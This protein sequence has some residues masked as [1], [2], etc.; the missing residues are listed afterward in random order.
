MLKFYQNSSSTATRQAKDYLE[1]W[2]L[3]YEVQKMDTDMFTKQ[4]F[5]KILSYLDNVH[6]ILSARSGT[7]KKIVTDNKLDLESL[8]LSE[9]YE[10]V[11]ENPTI[12]KTP[13]TVDY[14]NGRVVVGSDGDKLFQF[15][16]MEV[17]RMQRAIYRAD[18]E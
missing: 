2:D 4:E 3:K 16:S 12:L 6:T 1:E 13:L 7:Y 8:K 10:L 5:F 17:K 14:D 18:S 9:L 11:K 15:N